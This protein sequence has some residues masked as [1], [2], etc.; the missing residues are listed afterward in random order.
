MWFAGYRRAR[1]VDIIKLLMKHGF[2]FKT[3][4]NQCDN[5]GFNTFEMC[6]FSYLRCIEYFVS[7]EKQTNTKLNIYNKNNDSKISST[8]FSIISEM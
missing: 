7:I 6:Q 5:D 2:D 8:I 3:L 1:D 4:A